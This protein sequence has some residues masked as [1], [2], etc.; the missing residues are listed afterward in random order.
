MICLTTSLVEH[1]VKTSTAVA[2]EGWGYV[3]LISST[4]GSTKEAASL[5]DID[6]ATGF[7]GCY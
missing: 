1:L 5:K 4:S 2:V 3:G 7:E 6:D